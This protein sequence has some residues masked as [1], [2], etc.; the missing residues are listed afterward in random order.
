MANQQTELEK[1]LK[2]L[3]LQG[4]LL[5]VAMRDELEQLSTKEKKLLSEDGSF[6]LPTFRSSYDSWYSVALRVIEQV[7][8]NR[9]DDFVHQYKNDK[10]KEINYLTYTISDY[11][12]SVEMKQGS[13]IVSGVRDARPKF[14][15]QV[16]IL[17]SVEHVLGSSIVD[18]AEVLQ[19]DLFDSELD[20]ATELAKKGFVRGAGAIA[21][22]V[23]ERH[24]KHICEL[25]GLKSR[26]RSPTINDYNELLKSSKTI[27][28]AKW[29]LIQ[30]LGDL[31]NLCD[32]QADRDPTK[33]DVAEL[34]EGVAKITKTVF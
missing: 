29:R 30:H 33:D 7:L 20:A 14:Q 17:K 15:Q 34:V 18:L 4:D 11:L 5:L 13:R 1:E 12:L 6:K 16:N 3:I 2:G 31:R 10:R 8:P 21:G 24:L 28:T 32:H 23:L 25:H 9:L 19:A 27:D 26:K 22:V